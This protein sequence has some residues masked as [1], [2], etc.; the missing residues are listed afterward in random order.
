MRFREFFSP[1]PALLVIVNIKV[2]KFVV[3]FDPDCFL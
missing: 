3:V 1:F 2:K